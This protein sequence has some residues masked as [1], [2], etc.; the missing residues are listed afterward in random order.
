M[1]R[2]RRELLSFFMLP[3]AS[4]RDLAFIK[5]WAMSWKSDSNGKGM[6]ISQWPSLRLPTLKNE[7][8]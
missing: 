3:C 6:S 5:L 4:S 8:L 2:S 1:H 7:I